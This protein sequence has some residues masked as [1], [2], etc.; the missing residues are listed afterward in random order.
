MIAT[1]KDIPDYDGHRKFK[2]RWLDAQRNYP[3]TTWDV[4]VEMT[5]PRLLQLVLPSVQ[6]QKVGKE[7][8][9]GNGQGNAAFST[10]MEKNSKSVSIDAPDLKVDESVKLGD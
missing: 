1:A 8:C 2:I 3:H 5:H 6:A 4:E 7:L 10:K 9:R